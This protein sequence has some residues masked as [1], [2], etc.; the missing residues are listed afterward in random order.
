MV[1]DVNKILE[2]QMEICQ[3]F[4]KWFSAFFFFFLKNVNPS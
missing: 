4:D 1:A 2:K 3:N